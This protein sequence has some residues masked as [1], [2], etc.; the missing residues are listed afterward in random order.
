MLESRGEPG[1]PEG[2]FEAIGKMSAE[3]RVQPAYLFDR[4]VSYKLTVVVAAER[5]CRVTRR[6]ILPDGE[7]AGKSH[8][9]REPPRLVG[10]YRLCKK[11]AFSPAP[12]RRLLN[13]AHF[14]EAGRPHV[15]AGHGRWRLRVVRRYMRRSR[16]ADSQ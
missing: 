10:R 12:S 13:M 7:E 14:A 9:W 1:D 6:G 4:G 3:E 5:L 11:L 16:A 8:S 2:Y 15:G